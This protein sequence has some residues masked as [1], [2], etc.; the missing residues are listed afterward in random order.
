MQG[1]IPAGRSWVYPQNLI[2]WVVGVST[3]YE[4]AKR[5]DNS[6]GHC[7]R[8]IDGDHMVLA[9]DPPKMEYLVLRVNGHRHILLRPEGSLSLSVRDQICLEEIQTNLHSK[10]GIHLQINGQ[11]IE[12]GE[13]KRLEALC[14]AG[15]GKQHQIDIKKGP[16]FLGRL[17]LQTH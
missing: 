4:H 10:A 11:K 7:N 6:T 8:V 2:E 14:P 5:R 15:Q 3:S 17:F 9:L 13:M 16:L 12:P 1:Y